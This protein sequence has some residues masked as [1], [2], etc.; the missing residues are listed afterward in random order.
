VV[1]QPGNSSSA[2]GRRDSRI[3]A[4][5][6]TFAPGAVT[7]RRSS[8]PPASAGALGS[9]LQ[10][11]VGVGPERLVLLA[12]GG[13]G[14][15]EGRDGEHEGRDGEHEG[16]DGEAF[17]SWDDETPTSPQDLPLPPDLE[18]SDLR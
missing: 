16:R 1:K 18:R 9:D 6:Q 11:R 15:H 3:A 10:A 7:A 5:R 12:L 2:L 4:K 14:E 13:D 17:A 8:R